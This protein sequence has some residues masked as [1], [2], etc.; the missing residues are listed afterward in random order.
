[1]RRDFVHALGIAAL[2]SLTPSH[3]L[4]AA[5]TEVTVARGHHLY[6]VRQKLFRES[7]LATGHII[8]GTTVEAPTEEDKGRLFAN[9]FSELGNGYYEF[10]LFANATASVGTYKVQFYDHTTA[11]PGQTC[12]P[13]PRLLTVYVKDIV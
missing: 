2:I 9:N 8:S 4:L 7:R 5:V 11:K 13:L 3:V 10:D 12:R 6:D 1:M